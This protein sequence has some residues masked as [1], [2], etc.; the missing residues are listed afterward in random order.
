MTVAL[1]D[2][3]I[4]KSGGKVIKNVA[5]YDIAKLF[6][7]SFGTLGRDPVGQRPAAPAPRPTRP[8]RSAPPMTRRARAAAARRWRW[9][10]SSSRR[11]TS[12]GATARGGV[13]AQ[14]GRRRAPRRER[15]RVDS[16]DARGG[17]RGR[18]RSP[19]TSGRCGA[20]AGRPAFRASARCCACRSPPSAAGRS[21][22]GRPGRAR[23]HARRPRRARASAGSR[24]SPTTVRALRDAPA[25][26]RRL[27]RCS[28]SPPAMPRPARSVGRARRPGARADAPAQDAL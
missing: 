8:P 5:G 24:S 16:A 28:T 21:S 19:T 2:G 27:G 14:L 4:A 13:L 6:S 18:S 15:A 25:R 17:A 11:W 9:R 3:T 23:R 1:S 22:P 26:G 10:R 7:G 12:P 20:P